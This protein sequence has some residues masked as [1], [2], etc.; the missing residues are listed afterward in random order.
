MQ[1][2]EM[3]VVVVRHRQNGNDTLTEGLFIA[4]G[5]MPMI[6]ENVADAVTT[7]GLPAEV[8]TVGANPVKNGAMASLLVTGSRGQAAWL[9]SLLAMYGE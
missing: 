4:A 9:T 3:G 6:I 2:I 1:T 7:W 8:V 5:Q